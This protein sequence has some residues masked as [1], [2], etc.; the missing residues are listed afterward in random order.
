MALLLLKIGLGQKSKSSDHFQSYITIH[1]STK[2]LVDHD[3][4]VKTFVSCTNLWECKC[5][6]YL[7]DWETT[8]PKLFSKL[9]IKGYI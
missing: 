8:N 5:S 4:F 3:L 1:F 6:S 9:M 2:V 7:F